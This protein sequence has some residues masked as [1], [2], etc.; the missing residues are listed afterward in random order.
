MSKMFYRYRTPIPMIFRKNGML[1]PSKKIFHK[2]LAYLDWSFGK[3]HYDCLSFSYNREQA[4]SEC[5]LSIDEIRTQ[6]E[7]FIDKGMMKRFPSQFK[8]QPCTYEWVKEKIQEGTIIPI[9]KIPD[10][11]LEKTQAILREEIEKKS[12][13]ENLE[14]PKQNDKTPSKIPDKNPGILREEI[15]KNPKQN[16]KQNPNVYINDKTAIN[17]SLD[18]S[19]NVAKPRTREQSSLSSSNKLTAFVNPR[20]YRLRDGKHLSLRM[21]NALGKYS[22]REEERLLAN[23]QFYEQWVDM[24]K[25]IKT[26]HEVFLQSCINKDLALKK[27]HAQKNDLYAKFLKAEHEAHGIEILPTTVRLKKQCH[28]EPQ[29][30]SKELPPC[31]FEKIL[32]NYVNNYYPTEKAEYAYGN[33]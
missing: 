28:E 22:P 19:D 23:V 11:N 21:Q 26:N 14:N 4:S 12:Q 31:T 15:Q 27:E 20:T 16:P 24:G 17:L 13:T 8:N 10:E 18:N 2:R 25:I 29:S 9:E 33:R 3:C 32:E 6:E 1:D 5:G 30:I 7:Y